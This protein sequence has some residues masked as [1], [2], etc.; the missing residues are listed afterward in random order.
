MPVMT[1]STV[2]SEI[3]QEFADMSN[4]G[5]LII[6]ALNRKLEQFE[7]KFLGVL[8]EKTS[9][10]TILKT[11]LKNLQAKLEKMEQ[12][13]DDEDAYERRDTLILSG[14]K[15]PS[16]TTGENCGAI[17]RETLRNHLRINLNDSSISTAHRMGKK[18][19][20]Q[21]PDKRPIIVKL[22]RRDDKAQILAAARTIRCAGLFANE[23][24]TNNR[25]TI[26]YALR[27]M[28]KNHPNIV[29]GC[30]SIDGKVYALTKPLNPQPNARNTRHLILSEQKLR[31]FCQDFIKKPLEDFIESWTA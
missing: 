2:D 27:K 16:T 15:I 30:T 3:E 12:K 8:E 19:V 24:L 26:L 1:R 6:S 11:E 22:C 20:S 4:D 13:L 9:E 29:T 7:T 21:G 31:V 5:K 28:K 14:D 23:S 17:L 25:R 18:P 10:I